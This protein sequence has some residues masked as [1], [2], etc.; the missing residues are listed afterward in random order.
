MLEDKWKVLIKKTVQ[1]YLGADV[2]VFMFGSRA[3]GKNRRWSDVD[4]GISGNQKI[5]GSKL[6]EIE[7]DLSES[8]IPYLVEIVNFQSVSTEFAKVALSSKIDL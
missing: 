2:R 1:K 5:A 8:D 4:I 7:S 6:V 3:T